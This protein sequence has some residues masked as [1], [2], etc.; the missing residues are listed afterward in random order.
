[1]GTAD[2]SFVFHAADTEECTLPVRDTEH[3]HRRCGACDYQWPEPLPHLRD[4][5]YPS[6]AKPGE[7]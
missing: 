1:M 6:W 7:Q 5:H 2:S 4:R 3:L